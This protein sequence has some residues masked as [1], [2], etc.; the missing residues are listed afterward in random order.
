MGMKDANI[1]NPL[2]NSWAAIVK[3]M[4]DGRWYP[5]NTSLLDGRVLVTAGLAD[6]CMDNRQNNIPDLWQNGT[7]FRLFGAA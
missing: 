5:T 6:E 7:W 4:A 1:F 3:P 2:T